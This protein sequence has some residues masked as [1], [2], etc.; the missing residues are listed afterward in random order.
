MSGFLFVVCFFPF[1]LKWQ[2]MV[3]LLTIQK[4]EVFIVSY[5]HQS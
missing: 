5:T 2:E 3:M 1:L 4:T